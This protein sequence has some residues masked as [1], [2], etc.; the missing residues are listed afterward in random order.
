L[1][2]CSIE[3]TCIPELP[4]VNY[5]GMP[6]LLKSQPVLLASQTETEANSMVESG[7]GK[8]LVQLK[9]DKIVSSANKGGSEAILQIDNGTLSLIVL[10]VGQGKDEVIT[11]IEINEEYP[12]VK[13]NRKCPREMVLALSSEDSC[14]VSFKNSEVRDLFTLFLRLFVAKKSLEKFEKV[15]EETEDVKPFS[16]GSEEKI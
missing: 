7:K 1:L 12:R 2:R 6:I 8:I 14:T 9:E 3:V 16:E 11:S 15:Q 13:L 10:K 4:G 5:E